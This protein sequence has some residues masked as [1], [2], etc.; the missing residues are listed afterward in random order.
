MGCICYRSVSY[1]IA[2]LS[3]DVGVTA[4]VFLTR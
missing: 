3:G 2:V 4:D 1:N